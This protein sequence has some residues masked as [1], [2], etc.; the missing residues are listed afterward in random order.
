MRDKILE[1]MRQRDCILGVTP[2]HGGMWLSPLR[3]DTP[4][5]FKKT[6]DVSWTWTGFSAA[7]NVIGSD[8]FEFEVIYRLNVLQNLNYIFYHS[9]TQGSVNVGFTDSL[10]YL[11]IGRVQNPE[12]G[13]RKSAGAHQSDFA[14]FS[15]IGEW[16]SVV[17]RRVSGVLSLILNGRTINTTTVDQTDVWYSD[18]DPISNF[19][20]NMRSAKLLNLTTGETVWSASRAE[21]YET[22]NPWPSDNPDTTLKPI[23]QR[24]IHTAQET[25]MDMQIAEIIHDNL[26]EEDL[27]ELKNSGESLGVILRANKKRH[28]LLQVTCF[29]VGNYDFLQ[30]RPYRGFWLNFNP[31]SLYKIEREIVE[32]VVLPE[33]MNES[34]WTDDIEIWVASDD[35]C[36]IEEARAKRR[37]AIE[38]W[39]KRSFAD[40]EMFFFGPPMEL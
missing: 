35:V 32:R 23:P 25:D 29:C 12:T 26:S 22:Q 1:A 14:E 18:F 2:D 19:D 21:L 7:S 3:M 8:D 20:G 5:N 15:A 33:K 40:E 13:T 17:I 6:G 31:D 24:A 27:S 4:R 16:V 30:G 36:N 38:G 10:I 9:N 28:N 34:Y 11:T 39:K 37:K